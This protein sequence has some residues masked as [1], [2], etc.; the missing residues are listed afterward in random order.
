MIE[1][2]KTKIVRWSTAACIM[3]LVA[4]GGWKLG[5]FAKSELQRQERL[6][7]LTAQSV[8]TMQ[9]IERLYFDPVTG[10][11]YVGSRESIIPRVAISRTGEVVHRGCRVEGLSVPTDPTRFGV[12]PSLAG[13]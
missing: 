12:S 4:M 6:N 5:A 9:V 7:A 2:R 13:L 1:E 3:I 10:C 8:P 11:E